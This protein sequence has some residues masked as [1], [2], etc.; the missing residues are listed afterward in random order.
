[1]KLEKRRAVGFEDEKGSYFRYRRSWRHRMKFW[2]I[3]FLLCIIGAAAA[4][5]IRHLVETVSKSEFIR[6]EPVDVPPPD[7]SSRHYKERT[8]YERRDLLLRER[9]VKPTKE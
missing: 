7:I 8:E 5:Y 1:V 3:G 6:Y 4:L 2:L 9:K